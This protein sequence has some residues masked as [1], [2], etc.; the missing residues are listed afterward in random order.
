MFRQV[1]DTCHTQKGQTL[2]CMFLFSLNRIFAN[3]WRFDVAHKERSRNMF[4]FLPPEAGA[5]LA[6]VVIVIFIRM[7]L[8]RKGSNNPRGVKIKFDSSFLELDVQPVSEGDNIKFAYEHEGRYV[9]HIENRKKHAKLDLDAASKKEL[10][11]MVEDTFRAWAIV[12][13]KEPR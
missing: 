1:T 12:G 9:A 5:F 8:Q 11:K 7:L 13:K 4:S 10:E 6:L 2:L 3:K